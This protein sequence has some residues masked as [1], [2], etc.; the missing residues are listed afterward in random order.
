MTGKLLA[1]LAQGMGEYG[2]LTGGTSGATAGGASSGFGSVLNQA[3]LWF[4]D[5][6]LA[7][8]GGAV[9]LLGFIWWVTSPG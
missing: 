1:V 6:Q 5:H 4:S 9:V 8:I 2:A 7:V 3:T